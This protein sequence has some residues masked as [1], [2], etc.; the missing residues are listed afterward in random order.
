VKVKNPD[1]ED[2]S[3]PGFRLRSASYDQT[4]RRGRP[5]FDFTPEGWSLPLDVE[6]NDGMVE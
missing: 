6:W 4:R 5:G 3:S 2:P 1:P